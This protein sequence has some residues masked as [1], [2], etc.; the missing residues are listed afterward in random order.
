MRRVLS[1]AVLA[2]ALG[3]I[4][5]AVTSEAVNLKAGPL[6]GGDTLSPVWMAKCPDG[7]RLAGLRIHRDGVIAGV[8]AICVRLRS[9]GA[10]VVWAGTPAVAP[11]PP[12]PPPP[13]VIRRE[14][15]REAQGTVLRADSAGVTR[16]RGSRAMI[17]TIEEVEEQPF[18]TPAPTVDFGTPPEAADF[19]C[20]RG[21]FVKGL[22]LGSEHGRRGLRLAAVQLLCSDGSG[23]TVA[24]TGAWPDA[25][26]AEVAAK[27]AKKKSKKRKKA[28]AAEPAAPLSVQ[29]IECDGQ[30][31]N[32]HD[33][34]AA[35]AVFGTA[36]GGEVQTIGLSCAREADP[37]TPRTLYAKARRVVAGLPRLFGW[38]QTYTAPVWFD[39]A[40]LAV[41]APGALDR[42]CAQHSADRY[43]VAV[44][45]YDRATAY[46]V[47]RFAKA[48][49]AATGERCARG[50]CRAFAT[51][52]CGFGRS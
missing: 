34:A 41:C 8:Q 28:K 43:C 9:D 1:L 17:I 51:I 47:G 3:G 23:R 20:P 4:A 38:Q 30:S 42:D 2:L 48:S 7:Q 32:P 33:G 6:E 52:T 46:T 25:K 11:E 31:A 50:A 15:A 21:Q 29:R 49:V 16:R 5:P 40:Q 37:V 18:P 39:G 19:V 45:G 12:K 22:R 36:D 14:V 26:I 27:P 44:E 35:A 10:R 24:T 13:R